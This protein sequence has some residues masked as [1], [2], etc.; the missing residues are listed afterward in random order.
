MTWTY[1][2]PADEPK[3]AVRFLLGDTDQVR[4]LLS[5][6]EIEFLITE[7]D[8]NVYEAAALSADHL[9][10]KFAR[11]VSMSADGLSWQ[12]NQLFQ[13]FKELS[14]A[15]WRL[16]RKKS[17]ARALPYVGGISRAERE[18][19]DADADLV[20][21][22]FRSHMH[23]APGTATGHEAGGHDDLKSPGS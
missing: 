14:G 19:A 13:Q 1:D 6:E 11:E 23:D 18:R 21:T 9:V 16:A 22:H 10:A 3:D 20:P 4:P 12:G 17:G 15:L 7:A 2:D 5:D 8:D